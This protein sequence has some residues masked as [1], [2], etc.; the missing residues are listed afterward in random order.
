[1]W[2]TG[3]SL[4]QEYRDL[5][6]GPA[7]THPAYGFM[8]YGKKFVDEDFNP[9][10]VVEACVVVDGQQGIEVVASIWNNDQDCY[11]TVPVSLHDIEMWCRKPNPLHTTIGMVR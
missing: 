7:E 4:E 3:A 8:I 2:R 1:M 10:G 5:K 11:D 6:M 9:S